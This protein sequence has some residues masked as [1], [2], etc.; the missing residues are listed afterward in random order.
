MAQIGVSYTPSGGTPVYS[1]LFKT[2]TG[3]ELARTY[4]AT[5]QYSV[6][7]NGTSII[8]G[9]STRQKYIWAIEGPLALSDAQSFDAMFKAW[10]LDR[11]AGRSA[12]VGIT[13]DTFGTTVNT[14][15]IF[16]TPPTYTKF[17]SKYMLVAF[18]LSEV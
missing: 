8:A 17:G 2:F 18:G 13:D 6:S 3:S 1:F 7:A 11:A 14:S 15:A 9:P 4:N 16:S 10:D 12:A 5:A